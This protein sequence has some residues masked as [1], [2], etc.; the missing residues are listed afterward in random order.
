M[1]SDV[2]RLKNMRFFAYHGLFPEE[3]ILGQFYEVDLDLFSDLAVAGQTDFVEK[4]INYPDVYRLVEEVVTQQRFKLVE[5]LAEHIA[6]RVGQDFS[7]IALCVRV[8]KP[9]PPIPAHFDGIEVEL[10]RSYE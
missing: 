8:R 4:T 2:L 6:Q 7:P 10:H 1:P 5:A 9:N 3:N